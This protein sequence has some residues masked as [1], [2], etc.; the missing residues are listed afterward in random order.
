MGNRRSSTRCRSC[1][2]T[3][4]RPISSSCAMRR[5]GLAGGPHHKGLCLAIGAWR[6]ARFPR[7]LSRSTSSPTRL[8]EGHWTRRWQHWPR[9][10]E[11]CRF[12]ARLLVNP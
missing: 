10:D 1:S 5:Q 8:S 9:D 11:V 2:P 12:I 7:W 3:R 6:L 4:C